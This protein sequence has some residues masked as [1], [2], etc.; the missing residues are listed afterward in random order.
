MQSVVSTQPLL[1]RADASVD[2]GTGH[3]M[4]CLALAQAW[5]DRGGAVVFS[6]ARM[7]KNLEKSLLRRRLHVSRQ[8]FP[9]GTPEDASAVVNRARSMGV[10]WVMVDGYQFGAEFEE[11]LKEAGLRV[12]FVDDLGCVRRYSADIVLN[13]NSYADAAMYRSRAASTRLLLGPRYALLRREFLVARCARP[14]LASR[15]Q[16]LLVTIGGSDPEKI[17]GLVLDSLKLLRDDSL[18][19]R[20]VVGPANVNGAD[21]LRRQVNYALEVVD[22]ADMPQF[23]NWA[24]AAI[25]AAG[26]TTWELLYMGI[27]SL[28]IIAAENQRGNA[29]ALDASGAAINLGWYGQLRPADVAERISA[30]LADTQLRSRLREK[31]VTL[32]D[33]N[34]TQRLLRCMHGQRLN[35]RRTTVKD[36]QLLWKWANDAETRAASFTT[37][38][39]PWETHLAW[40]SER[41][42]DPETFLYIA[43]DD[44]EP[45]GQLRFKLEGDIAIVSVSVAG[46]HRGK[47]YGKELL[48][49]GTDKV[50]ED[51]RAKTVNAYVKSSNAASQRAFLRAGFKVAGKVTMGGQDAILL[52]RER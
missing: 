32:V 31:G 21:L 20:V 10:D 6:S 15:A 3:V 7:P 4:R 52:V 12:L 1:I 19:V 34:G 8:P 23:M 44:G 5:Q 9:I 26:I 27:P 25:S 40:F 11:S 49:L 38:R 42:V 22:G 13:Q 48:C 47:G 18:E 46:E 16:R 17:T 37:A 43:V 28:L 14:P 33:G 30:M 45:I 51:S 39:I 35:I 29:E 36:A 50:F 24:D 41:L 2:I